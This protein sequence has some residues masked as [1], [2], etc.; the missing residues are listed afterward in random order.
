MNIQSFTGQELSEHIN[1][2]QADLDS[3]IS[4][5]SLKVDNFLRLCRPL[6]ILNAKTAQT[7]QVRQALGSDMWQ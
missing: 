2:L 5:K 4:N 6:P 7:K 3:L 1:V